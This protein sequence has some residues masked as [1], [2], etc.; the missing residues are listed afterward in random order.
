MHK[1]TLFV[2]ATTLFLCLF[3]HGIALALTAE[4]VLEK[5]QQRYS[6]AH[7]YEA[8]YLI[9]E[10]MGQMGSMT[11]KTVIKALPKEK[12][13]FIV[14]EPTGTG[15][16]QMAM[17][18]A[19][20]QM[21]SISD[22]K[23]VYIYMKSTNSYMKMPLQNGVSTR[24]GGLGLFS[25]GL[26]SVTELRKKLGATIQ[27]LPS[28]TFNGHHV[29]VILLKMHPPQNASA[30][31][32]STKLFIEKGTYRILGSVGTLQAQGMSIQTTMRLV[33][34]KI[35]LP[36]PESLFHFTPP[37]G[38]TEMQGMLSGT[39]GAPQTGQ[40]NKSKKP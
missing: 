24:F 27:M 29:Y 4:E 7:S 31:P 11:M 21:E 26:P 28:T 38:A 19:M 5:A 17:A 33:S 25:G 34:D 37:P 23:T 14:S 1:K 18:A 32:V 39:V 40:T 6:N 35:N 10:N 8:T 2:I 16:G 3:T 22:G 20:A 12:K 36:L 15:T 9:T 30:P 13:T